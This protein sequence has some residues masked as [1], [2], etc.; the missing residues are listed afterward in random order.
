MKKAFLVFMLMMSVYQLKAQTLFPL[1]PKDTTAGSKMYQKFFFKPG[2]TLA[3]KLNPFFNPQV[4]NGKANYLAFN[5]QPTDHM[6][7]AR[8][9]NT[10][11]MPIIKLYNDSKMPIISPSTNQ[12]IVVPGPANPPAKP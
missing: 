3:G 5:K 12:V 4:L 6:P 10:S 2:D 11:K 9:H 7:I 8:L 1:N